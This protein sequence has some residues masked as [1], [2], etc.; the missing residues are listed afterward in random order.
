MHVI[1]AKAVAFGEALEPEFRDY[2]AA[3][4][5]NARAL[6]ERLLARGAAIVQGN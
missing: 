5:A 6:A 4:V 3:M 1:V 2:A